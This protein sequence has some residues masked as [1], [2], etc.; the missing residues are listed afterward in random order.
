[1][2]SVRLSIALDRSVAES[3]GIDRTFVGRCV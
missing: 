3:Y 1:M 2:P